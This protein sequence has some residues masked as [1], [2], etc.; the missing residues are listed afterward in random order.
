MLKIWTMY[1]G[2][3]APRRCTKSQRCDGLSD[4]L[5]RRRGSEK[6]FGNF[7]TPECQ[8]RTTVVLSLGLAV[9]YAAPD[10]DR[11]PPNLS[12]T[13]ASMCSMS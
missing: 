1:V 2:N 13:S 11:L 10:S 8:H 9:P 3:N 6:I 4:V 5:L 12:T 7:L